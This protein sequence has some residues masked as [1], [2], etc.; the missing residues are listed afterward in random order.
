MFRIWT[1]ERLPAAWGCQRGAR[2]RG[3]QERRARAGESCSCSHRCCCCSARAPAGLRLRAR[4]RHP[5]SICGRLVSGTE[6][7][8]IPPSQLGTLPNC[9]A[10]GGTPVLLHG[11]GVLG[12]YGKSMILRKQIRSRPMLFGKRSLTTTRH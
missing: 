11:S 9:R 5:P 10:S 12:S 1:P 8:C 2:R 7:P 4:P 3:A 6:F